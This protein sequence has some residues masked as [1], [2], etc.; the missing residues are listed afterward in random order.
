MGLV[1]YKETI[2]GLELDQPF[3]FYYHATKGTI[4]YQNA[5]PLPVRYYKH[6]MTKNSRVER[7][8]PYFQTYYE[9]FQLP[10]PKSFKALSLFKGEKYVWFYKVGDADA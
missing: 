1:F 9:T 5:F 7:L 8:I 3:E 4:T 2:S 6:W 10:E